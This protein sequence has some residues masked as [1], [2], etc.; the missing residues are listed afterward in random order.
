M[1]PT[2]RS[3]SIAALALAVCAAACGGERE[4]G[5]SARADSVARTAAAPSPSQSR[6]GAATDAGTNGL[7]TIASIEKRLDLQ[8]MVPRRLPAPVS[9]PFLT[10]PGTAYQLGNAELQVFIY[11]DAA[12]LARDVS[13][14]DTTTVSPREAPMQWPRKATLITNANLAAILLGEN[15]LQI[16]RVQRAVMAGTGSTMFSPAT[17]R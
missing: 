10:V 13:R 8:G 14:L 12:A 2:V 11:E 4:A 15:A 16:E 5:D 17:P 3:R 1:S 9:Y 6:S 7:W